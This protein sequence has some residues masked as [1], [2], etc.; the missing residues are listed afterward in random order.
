MAA[1]SSSIQSAGC[2]GTTVQLSASIIL[3]HFTEF[4]NKFQELTSLAKERFEDRQWRFARNDAL[5][6]MSLYEQALNAS[7]M[8]LRGLLGENLTDVRL[9]IEIKAIFAELIVPRTDIDIA[10]TFFNSVTRKIHQTI[11]INRDIEFFDLESKVER[12]AAREPVYERYDT[13]GLHTTTLIRR[14][15][16][17]YAFRT[18][19]EDLER[20][21]VRVADELDLY[22]WPLVGEG[23]LDCIEMIRVPFYR[24]RAAYLV[25]RLVAGET[26]IPFIMPLYNGN[27]GIYVDAALFRER[28]AS[29]IFSFAHSSFCVEIAQHTE[30][31]DFL[32]SIL[33]S[34]PLAELYISIGYNKHAKTEFYRYLHHYVHESHTR[35]NIAPGQE[36]SVMIGFTLRDFRFVFKVVKDRPCY[37]RSQNRPNKIISR[38]EVMERYRNVRRQDHV[39]RLVDTQE[40]ENL[41][42]RRKRFAPALLREFRLA[43]TEA[44]T[45][46]R[47]Y[48]T[49]HH[50]YLQR[51]VVPLPMYIADEPDPEVV[52]G[53]ILDYGYCLKDLASVGIFPAD[54][55]NIWNCGV[56]SRRRVVL[57]DHDDVTSLRHI[58]FRTKPR[59]RSEWEELQKEEDRIAA[60][61]NDFFIDEIERFLG[62]PLP[63]MGV[64]KKIHGDLFTVRYWS[65][66][67]GQVNRGDV[68]NIIP[69]DRSRRF[70][71][72]LYPHTSSRQK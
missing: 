68:V 17:S 18:P 26:I 65:K 5:R 22:V 8:E 44:V 34:K 36:G 25:G 72:R 13:G 64:F 66:L 23:M 61:P 20:D 10:R 21:A 58:Q 29:I 2:T 70:E 60:G 37:L 12:R 42:F 15:L 38:P 4:A 69:Y 59:P 52:R 41:R 46:D 30:L 63:L 14:I 31:L 1:K 6:R 27:R 32:R 57:F 28:Q 51:R 62:I 55:F 7:H 50:C 9:W 16:E 39:G 19:F 54:L 71:N 47:D 48:V 56:T 53:V 40:F 67:Q 35:F 3:K 49:I 45:I 11:G 33:P 24:N 43:A